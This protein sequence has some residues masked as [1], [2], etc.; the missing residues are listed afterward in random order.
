[1]LAPITPVPTHPTLVFPGS[2]TCGAA[3]RCSPRPPRRLHA[4]ADGSGPTVR[5]ARSGGARSGAHVVVVGAVGVGCPAV[6]GGGRRRRR[7]QRAVADP[8]GRGP[9][10]PRDA[11]ERHVPP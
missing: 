6:G 5:S 3:I 1:M 7:A 9:R 8:Q 2:T 11:G 4:G 10:L